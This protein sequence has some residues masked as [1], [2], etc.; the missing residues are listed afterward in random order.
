MLT[1]H[2]VTHPGRVRK[3]NEDGFYYDVQ[4][5]LYLVADGLGGHNAGEIASRLALES[6]L[7]FIQR[8]REDEEFTW[9]F[10]VETALS[11]DANRIRTALRRANRR[12]FQM[13]ESGPQY[14]G[15]GT[16]VVAALVSGET[17]TFASVGDSR[18]YLVNDHAISQVTEDDSWLSALKA[19]EPNIDASQ[20]ERHPLRHVITKAIGTLTDTEIT[21]QER[22]LR[23]GDTLLLCTDGLH[24]LVPEAKMLEVVDTDQTL[25]ARAQKLIDLALEAGGRDNVTALLVKAEKHYGPLQTPI[26]T[27]QNEPARCRLL[28]SL[29]FGVWSCSLR[30][31]FARDA[32]AGNP[33]QDD[34]GLHQR[35]AEPVAAALRP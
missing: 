14:G 5:G 16:T 9:P 22:P 30:K 34:V 32:P 7:G 21:I 8:T 2:G 6:V 29:E 19:Q 13:S 33:L 11:Y 31:H 15:M 12:V 28:W 1:V 18:M 3:I 24:D 35:V 20:L 17:L 4:L 25:E 27:P 10:G 26:F 23:H